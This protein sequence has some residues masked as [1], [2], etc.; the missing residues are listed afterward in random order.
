MEKDK[1]RGLYGKWHVIRVSDFETKHDDCNTFVLDLTHDPF[2]R[3]CLPSYIEKCEKDYPQLA[4]DL[5]E[6]LRRNTP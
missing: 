2:A 1:K 3:F 6:L 4:A 5:R